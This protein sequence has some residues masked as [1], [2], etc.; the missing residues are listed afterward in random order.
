MKDSKRFHS[1]KIKEVSDYIKENA[2]AW[3]I[4]YESEETIDKINIRQATLKSMQNSIKF[5]YLNI[6]HLI[7]YMIITNLLLTVTILNQQ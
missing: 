2:I 3:T 4:T 7:S 5:Y 6:K 1:E